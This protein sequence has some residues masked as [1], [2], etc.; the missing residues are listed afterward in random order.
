MAE[1]NTFAGRLWGFDFCWKVVGF[2]TFPETSCV[3]TCQV[4]PELQH[5]LPYPSQFRFVDLGIASSGAKAAW[6]P[7][8]LQNSNLGTYSEESAGDSYYCSELTV[9]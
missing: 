5:L 4:P 6:I 7:P 9:T 8:L 3:P 2:L 1:I